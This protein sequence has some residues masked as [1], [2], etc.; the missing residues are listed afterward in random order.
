MGLEGSNNIRKSKINN[1]AIYI[2][3]MPLAKNQLCHFQIAAKLQNSDLLPKLLLRWF[4]E[5]FIIFNFFLHLRNSGWGFSSVGPVKQQIADLLCFTRI[6]E[7]LN[8]F[9]R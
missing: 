8:R 5:C 6:L 3:L 2:P 7:N 1:D 4:F 9:Q